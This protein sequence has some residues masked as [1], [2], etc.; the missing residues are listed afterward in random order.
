MDL[1]FKCSIFVVILTFVG[2][3]LWVRVEWGRLRCVLAYDGH[4]ADVCLSFIVWWRAAKC[5]LNHLKLLRE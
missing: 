1:I 5:E 2:L 4:V 3:S